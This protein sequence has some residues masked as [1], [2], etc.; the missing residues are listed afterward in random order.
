MFN[1]PLNEATGAVIAE[2]I[3]SS[4]MSLCEDAGGLVIVTEGNVHIEERKRVHESR[5]A[6]ARPMKPGDEGMVQSLFCVETSTETRREWMDKIVAG[7]ALTM[8]VMPWPTCVVDALGV[9]R[10]TCSETDTS[11]LANAF[12]EMDGYQLGTSEGELRCPEFIHAM[13][14]KIKLQMGVIVVSP[15]TDVLPAWYGVASNLT[16][17]V[18]YRRTSAKD[19]EYALQR[20]DLKQLYA[21]PGFLTGIYTAYMALHSDFGDAL[22]TKTPIPLVKKLVGVAMLSFPS[23]DAVVFDR[24]QLQLRVNLSQLVEVLKTVRTATTTEKGEQV[25]KSIV[26]KKCSDNDIMQYCAATLDYTASVVG[27]YMTS[28]LIGWT[29]SART[30]ICQRVETIAEHTTISYVVPRK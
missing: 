23:V 21:K 4:Y 28:P 22:E 6:R 15:D 25:E 13:T 12:R 20:I 11:E 24:D 29:P 7:I 18:M 26:K 16:T 1:V 2:H 14:Q 17:L 5:R 30:E 9:A 10:V 3:C 19:S 8:Q 27:Y